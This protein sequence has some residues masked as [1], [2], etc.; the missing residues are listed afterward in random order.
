MS[1]PVKTINTGLKARKGMLSERGETLRACI[2]NKRA[3]IS[4]G[5]KRATVC[6]KIG[7]VLGQD[8]AKSR[9]NKKGIGAVD[10]AI[11]ILPGER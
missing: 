8:I 4:R 6:Q 9:G 2:Y 11:A 1:H 5:S 10:L 7:S 3:D